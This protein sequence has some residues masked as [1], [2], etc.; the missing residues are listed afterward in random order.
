MSASRLKRKRESSAV[1]DE[2]S[3]GGLTPTPS[4]RAKKIDIS[5]N[6]LPTTMEAS[7][8]EMSFETEEARQYDSEVSRSQGKAND[9][10]VLIPQPVHSRSE[11]FFCQLSVR[12]SDF[13]GFVCSIQELW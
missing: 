11:A 9:S 3:S 12:I 1:F 13:F 7:L 6:L 8:V 2:I 4:V 5:S 10:E